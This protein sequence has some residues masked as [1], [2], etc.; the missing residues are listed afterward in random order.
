MRV[1]SGNIWRHQNESLKGTVNFCR[2]GEIIEYQIQDTFIP[3]KI[4]QRRHVRLYK[5]QAGSLAVVSWCR[6][7]Q[8]DKIHSF[9][10]PPPHLR[11]THTLSAYVSH[12][13]GVVVQPIN[14]LQCFLKLS[15]KKENKNKNK[16][17]LIRATSLHIHNML[18]VP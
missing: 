5:N 15:P 4:M 16:A 3:A 6:G 1:A 10:F 17:Q 9:N 2:I 11:H 13:Y 7:F 18:C 14:T 8:E 12:G